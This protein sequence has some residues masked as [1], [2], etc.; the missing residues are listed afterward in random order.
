[1]NGFEME[2]EMDK[3]ESGE[4]FW[5]KG[6]IG[7]VPINEISPD[8]RY[9]LDCYNVLKAEAS[10]SGSWRK[11]SWIP[12]DN[13]GK[14]SGSH[15]TAME[16]NKKPVTTLWMVKD[17]TLPD[18]TVPEA[19][20]IKPQEYEW[21]PDAVISR[22]RE[23]ASQGISTRSIS[24]QLEKEGVRISHMTVARKLQSSID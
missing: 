15:H 9:C 22:C 20:F 21:T 7:A 14:L 23:L 4:Y 2:S 10:Q 1:M 17:T 3:I 11:A 6:H 12:K 5:C 13:T 18:V 8:R 24:A 16:N 19:D